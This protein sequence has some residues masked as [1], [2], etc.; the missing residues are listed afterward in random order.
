MNEAVGAAEF[1][2]A[3][4]YASLALTYLRGNI[5]LAEPLRPEHLRP[6]PLGHWGC[7]PGIAFVWAGLLDAL[8]AYPSPVRL[9]V[10]TGHAG[11]AWLGCALAEGG[12]PL[13]VRC[14]RP[15]LAA[16]PEVAAAYGAVGGFATELSPA[17]PGLSWTT[18]ELG[19][20]AGIAQGL[21]WADPNTRVVC[22]IGDG[23]LEAASS[24]QA[25][26][27]GRVL[28]PP[29]MVV[30]ND[31]GLRM[32]GAS[33]FGSM[34]RD[35]QDALLG[36]L[37]WKLEHLE[38]GDFET[39][40][41]SL[42]SALSAGE[43][44]SQ[45]LVVHG[46]KGAGCPVLPNGQP[47]QGS[48]TAHKAPLPDGNPDEATA[49][50]LDAWLR[51]FR[52]GWISE[53]VRGATS[54]L[55][56]WLPPPA[57][58]LS[59]AR[60]Q[61]AGSATTVPSPPTIHSCPAETQTGIARAAAALADTAVRG[62]L[63][64]TSPDEL[65]SNRLAALK[66]AEGVE[67]C[68]VLNEDLC[69]AWTIGS[70]I[71]GRPAWHAGYEAFASLA[72]SLL[73]QH[74]K[75]LDAAWE[76]GAPLPAS[77][78]VLLTSL[79]WRN[80]P[81][82]RDTAIHSA[83]LASEAASLRL[84]FPVCAEGVQACV[85]A[86]ATV[87]GRVQVMVVD[88]AV[89]LRSGWAR[90]PEGWLFDGRPGVEEPL[91]AL[92]VVVGDVMAR[93]AERAVRALVDSPAGVR[94]AALAVEELTALYR[95]DGEALRIRGSLTTRVTQAEHV[96]IAAAPA[97]RLATELLRTALGGAVVALGSTAWCSAAQPGLDTLLR[98]GC[99]W[100]QMAARAAADCASRIDSDRSAAL[101]SLNASLNQR[102]QEVEHTLRAHEVQDWHTQ[103]A[104]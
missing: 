29:P 51:S 43:T 73:A 22:V 49:G 75:H 35:A 48:T 98:S 94:A 25:L 28:S 99:T 60:P 92:F 36:G 91:D 62:P 13:S 87:P 34:E 37:G 27:A 103:P 79:G 21:A 50:W 81:S 17:Y 20:A 3:A 96:Y 72:S 71:G 70:A 9:L 67:V 8:S 26:A 16:L 56:R 104:E 101:R 1:Y 69:V 76:L 7:T 102:W 5:D 40:G 11:P 46:A 53:V 85:D 30:I 90:R 4:V 93:E 84:S 52:P 33:I 54:P 97:G 68:E 82:H 55:E 32:G 10:G 95:K 88:K 77:V 100:F 86:V 59:A 12:A 57:R 15:G 80:V 83:L 47:V 64:V 39:V 14:D 18:G 45:A 44:R 31:N 2:R 66:E 61:D 23:E 58:R 38:L 42:R 19:H 41:A 63:L 89:A 24:L 6:R 78:G 65:S 74:L